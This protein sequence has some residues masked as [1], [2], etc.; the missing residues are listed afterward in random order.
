MGSIFKIEVKVEGVHVKKRVNG[1]IIEINNIELF[2]AA[3]EGL[4]A[5]KIVSSS[6]SDMV[7]KDT[8]LINN[9]ISAYDTVYR[10]L[11]FPLY[12]IEQGIK[13]ATIATSIQSKLED[14][15]KMWVDEALYIKVEQETALKF[16]GDTYGIV[17]IE[18]REY[19]DNTDISL[20]KEDVGY[21]EFSWALEKLMQDEPL[22]DY[23]NKFM[24]DFIKACSKEP[25]VL[26]FELSQ[27]LQF[28]AIPSKTALKNNSIIEVN[29][30]SEFLMDIYST[31]KKKTN[32]NELVI[33]LNGSNSNITKKA[34]YIQTY[35]FDVYEK[36]R[37]ASDVLNKLKKVNIDGF[38][39]LFETLIGKGII[40][41]TLN[42]IDYRGLIINNKMV[43]QVGSQIFI[44]EY[45]KYTKPV[46]IGKNVEIYGYNEGFIYIVKRVVC[47][48]KVCKESIY[49][50]NPADM[51]IKLCKIQFI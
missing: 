4:A 41:D 37:D 43:Y 23:Y 3:F 6:V 49:R 35:S 45:N 39:S 14:K 51:Q 44:C 26:K 25:L 7:I 1:K 38:A 8:E 33:S 10:C 28:D 48:S 30:G 9:C 32:E 18:D 36:K 19:K 12:A 16:I 2:E 22:S 50:L 24:P 27:M 21:A 5:K 11:P 46:E 29:T 42:R 17:K 13:Y 40:N 31:G 34:K 20:Y 47:K 15:L